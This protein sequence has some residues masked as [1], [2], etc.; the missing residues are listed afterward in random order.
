MNCCEMENSIAL[1]FPLSERYIFLHHRFHCVCVCVC[2]SV[3]SGGAAIS[4]AA[5]AT[6]AAVVV[7]FCSW[8][9]L[10]VCMI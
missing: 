5:V 8:R 4:A 2:L 7:V 9:V 6:A 1:T 3:H 10:N